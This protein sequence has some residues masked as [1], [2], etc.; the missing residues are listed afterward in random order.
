M[1][2]R[3]CFRKSLWVVLSWGLLTSGCLPLDYTPIEERPFYA[4][5]MAQL[6]AFKLE[7]SPEGPLLAGSARVDISPPV[8]LPL[9][10]YGGRKSTGVNDPV[11]ARALVVSNGLS[12]I[13]MVSADLLAITDDLTR[14]VR[15]EVYKDLPELADHVMITATHTHSGPGALAQRFWERLAA[16]SFNRD[17]FNSTVKKMAEAVVSAAYGLRPS[18]IALHRLDASDLIQNRIIPEGPEDPEVQVLL[19]ESMDHH[20]RTYLIN[21]SAH[22]TVLRSK[23]RLL[24]GDFPGFLSRALE[25]KTGTLA[26]YTSGGVADQ[27]AKPPQGSNPFERAEKMGQVLAA[28]ILESGSLGRPQEKV[29]LSSTKVTIPLPPPQPKVGAKWRL[30]AWFGGLLFDAET[31]LQIFGIN[32]IFLI[33]VPADV[34]SELALSWKEMARSK[35]NSTV[36]ISFANDYIGYVM[37][38]DYYDKPIHEASMSFNGPYTANYL[39]EFIKHAILQ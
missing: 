23:N 14:A 24:S 31:E 12:K 39:D 7:S 33:G 36:V 37:P 27:K 38:T 32:R 35:G 11:Y 13:A 21:F 18:T 9:A 22:P 26:L 8:G 10:G 19:F 28:R 20:H 3:F 2:K 34:G 5:A 15:Q 29:S 17:Y 1:N 6:E 16:G 4:S 25:E 30:P